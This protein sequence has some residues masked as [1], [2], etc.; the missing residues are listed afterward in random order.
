MDL[1][2]LES[3]L[4]GLVS[5]LTDILPV[6]AQAHRILLLK[7]F[8]RVGRSDLLQFLIYFG[9]FAALYFSS[10]KHLVR[11]TRAQK[12]AR[13]PK[14][15]RKRPLDTRSLMDLSLLKTIALPVLLSLF[16]YQ[17]AKPLGDTLL[18]VVLFL[19]VN[20]IIL[21]I[22]QYLPS[23]NR[24]CRTLSRVEGLLMGLGGG[25]GILPGISGMGSATAV[26]S[27]CGVDRSYGLT[28][29]LMMNMVFS[30]GMMVIS[31]INM[32]SNGLVE[33]LSLM[34]LL[35]YLLTAA[36]AFGGTLLGIR[37]M[38]A[39]ASSNGYGL[40][41]FYCWGLALFTFILNLLA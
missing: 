11:M 6:S 27:V 3:V 21:Y 33:T 13:V 12:L 14:R 8:G 26:A 20:G 25:L 36:A 10:Q 2:W 1:N 41:G 18:F 29:A 31:V 40:F 28:M 17:Y 16:A 38:R 37:I 7:V 15:R 24:D 35:R 19:F 23:G 30:A 4:Y 39:M 22:P 5:G 32:L 9:I 34:L